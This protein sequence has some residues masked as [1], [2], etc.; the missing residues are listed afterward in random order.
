M[1]SLKG[2]TALICGA[3]SGIG[4]A[5]AKNFIAN[6]AET[7]I[8]GRRDEG[9]E[10]AAGIGAQFIRCDASVET[11]VESCLQQA[12]S[13][14]GKLDILV[15]NAGIADDEGSIE[16]FSG[17]GM[18]AIINTNLSGVFYALKYGPRHMND[19]GSIINTGSAA[20]SGIA[21][22]GAGVYAASKAGGAYLARTAAIENAPR[23]IRVNSV[24]PAMIA[25]TGMMVDDDGGDDARF[26]ATLTA[27]GRMGRQDEVLGIYNFLASDASTFITGQEIRVDGGATA[28]IGLPIFGAIAGE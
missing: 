13:V 10:I 7:I 2:K 11:D 20:G 14:L 23:E 4:L 9:A 6:G 8:T 28:G 3:T 1:H 26:L 21:H 22:A 5:V 15:I 16:E 25:G 17:E 24:C 19:G 12:E 18:Q 27:F